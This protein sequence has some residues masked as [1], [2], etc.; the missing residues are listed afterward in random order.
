[1]DVLSDGRRSHTLP[2]PP[3]A[4]P[5]SIDRINDADRA[6]LRELARNKKFIIEIGTFFGGSAETMLEASD[7]EMIC[8]D[9]FAGTPG[10]ETAGI[11]KQ[12]MLSYAALRLERFADR[13]S[14]IVADSRQ[15]ARFIAPGIADLIFLDAAHDYKN[16][17]AD[18]AAWL[19]KLKAGGVF[20]GHDMYKWFDLLT[21]EEMLA[22]RDDQMEP[23]T[24][25]HCG[26]H[27]AVTE[28][29]QTVDLLGSIDSSI[30]SAKPD[31]SQL[32]EKAA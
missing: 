24:G 17:R 22:R 29:F 5:F 23:E 8:I 10:N 11:A 18:I 32:Q 9:T 3:S 21:P 28:T 14:I 4:G 6:A 1:M 27:L 15:A 16:V 7:A 2:W 12:V 31:Q 25:I 13:V 19:P 26:V 20:S 30:W